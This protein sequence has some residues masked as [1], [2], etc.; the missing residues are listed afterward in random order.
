MHVDIDCFYC[1]VE[2]LDRP[3]F[4]GRPLVVQ[5][6]NRGGFVAVSYE[7]KMAGI[8]KGDGVGAGGRANI[9]RLQEI[10]VPPIQTLH[11]SKWHC[12][13]RRIPYCNNTPMSTPLSNTPIAP[14]N[15]FLL[16]DVFAWFIVP[17]IAVGRF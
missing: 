6:F 16:N 14:A 9:P 4:K 5:Q 1:Q 11:M 2:V 12:R 3:E 15:I 17:F 8:K 7:A 13:L 10:G